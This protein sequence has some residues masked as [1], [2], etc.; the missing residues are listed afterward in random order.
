MANN[1]SE[2]KDSVRNSAAKSKEPSKYSWIQLTVFGIVLLLCAAL[3]VFSAATVVNALYMVSCALLIFTAAADVVSALKFR[4]AEGDWLIS[5]SEGLLSLAGGIYFYAAYRRSYTFS[6]SL[7]IIS[8][9]AFL[10]AVLELAAYLR[11]TTR[12]KSRLYTFFIAGLSGICLFILRD[13]I[14]RFILSY[15]GYIFALCGLLVIII[16]QLKRA[17]SKE[18]GEL[19][20][21]KKQK[22]PPKQLADPNAQPETEGKPADEVVNSENNSGE[23][24]SPGSSEPA[25]SE[26]PPDEGQEAETAQ[27][28]EE[29]I[30]TEE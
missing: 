22:G 12:K 4:N 28:A 17:N 2:N 16:G 10:R 23:D 1:Q 21:R 20:S 30:R 13:L 19:S 8:V 25:Q 3:L 5:L 14:E 27:A 6:V 18:L 15:L 24:H 9:W 11:S 26:E 7:I 29:D